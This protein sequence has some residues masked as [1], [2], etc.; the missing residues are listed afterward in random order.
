LHG[1][2]LTLFR[3][4]GAPFERLHVTLTTFRVPVHSGTQSVGRSCPSGWFALDAGFSLLARS[5]NATGAAATSRGGRW[6]LENNG[7]AAVLADVQLVC[8]RVG[9]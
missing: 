9:P 1:A 3:A 4:A 8:G 2:C 5:T 7:D 6:T